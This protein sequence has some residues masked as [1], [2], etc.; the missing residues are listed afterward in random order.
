VKVRE[1]KKK[2]RRYRIIIKEGEKREGEERRRREKEKREGEERRRRE[3][4]KRIPRPRREC[5]CK[6]SQLC[7]SKAS[8]H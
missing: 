6:Q 3:K 5:R 1:E 7:G 4:E 2:L 8:L